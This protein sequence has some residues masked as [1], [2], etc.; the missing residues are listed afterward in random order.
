MVAKPGLIDWANRI[1]L[2]G[3]KRE[4]YMDPLAAIGSAVHAAI[5][6]DLSGLA[7]DEAFDVLLPKDKD[8]AQNCYLSFREWV[9]HKIIK[10]IALEQSLISESMKYGGTFDFLGYVD[11]DLELIDFK[12]GGIWPESFIQLAAYDYLIVENGLIPSP[13]VRFRVLSVPREPDETFD[14]KSKTSIAVDWE[15]FTL[16]HRLYELNKKRYQA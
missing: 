14:E 1:G 4:D 7:A 10:P 3:I 11:G 6:L 5:K 15:R 13:I 12:T 8:I 2:D 9:K 16:Y